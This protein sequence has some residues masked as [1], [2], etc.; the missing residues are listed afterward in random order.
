MSGTALAV[1]AVV[2]AV[3]ALVQG[4]TGFGFALIVAPVLGIIEPTFIPVLLL[5]LMIPLNAYVAW[6]ERTQIDVRGAQW[7]TAGRAVGALVGLV[8]LAAVPAGKLGVLIGVS[9]VL[10]AVA[11]LFAPAFSP[12]RSAC[13]MAGVVTGITETSTGIGGPPLALVY[14]H[15]P[16]A[17]LRSTVA[18]CFLV[19]EVL[20]L[21]L[22]AVGGR[23][24]G[25]QLEVALLLLPAL[26]VGA[27]ASR[28]VHHR[29]EGPVVRVA[30]LTFAVVSGLIAIVQS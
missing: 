12:G 6:R 7:I 11:A 17:V 27:L 1:V 30:V 28:W 24:A 29:L 22:L 18:V 9:T 20:S 23:V 5:V 26:A 13:A 15:R 10:A 4:S 3:A 19:G 2:V 16:A 8:V 21:G 25:A 14:Q